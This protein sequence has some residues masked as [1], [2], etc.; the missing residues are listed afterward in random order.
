MLFFGS[1]SSNFLKSNVKW[2]PSST[3]HLEP[4][5]KLLNSLYH[6]LIVHKFGGKIYC[7]SNFMK[8]N[9]EGKVNIPPPR[10]GLKELQSVVVHLG[11]MM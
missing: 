6:V 3:K 2:L 8:K 10:I 7:G 4:Y 11:T 9:L 1:F 5:P